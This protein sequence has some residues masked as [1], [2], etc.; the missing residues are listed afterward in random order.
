[1]PLA[2]KSFDYLI[3]FNLMKMQQNR[4]ETI[5]QTKNMYVFNIKTNIQTNKQSKTLLPTHPVCFSHVL[6]SH[7]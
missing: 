2:E 6:L 1:M 5:K 4:N 3:L 7:W